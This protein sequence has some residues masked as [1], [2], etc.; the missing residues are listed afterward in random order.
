MEVDPA[1]D[2]FG[3][4]SEYSLAELGLDEDEGILN[5]LVAEDDDEEVEAFEEVLAGQHGHPLEPKRHNK[6]YLG[7]HNN[8]NNDSL[9]QAETGR[10]VRLRGG[11][12]SDLG[13]KPHIV[14]FTKGKAGTIYSKDGININTEYT[15]EIGVSDNPYRPFSSKI[16]WEIARWAKIRGPSS[17]AFTELMNI[18]G[19][20]SV[21]LSQ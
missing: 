1:G 21:H 20:G 5:D 17:T 14:N 9:T 13:K 18:E 2:Y 11:A 10:A 4:Y 6:S 19:V 8:D 3:D 15:N 12:E 7:D 16:E